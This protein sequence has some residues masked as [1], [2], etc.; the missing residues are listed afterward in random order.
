MR[1]QHIK[2]FK[3]AGITIQVNSAYPFGKDTFSKHIRLFETDRPEKNAIIINHNFYIPDHSVYHELLKN[4]VF[5]TEQWQVY[6]T[7]KNWM[8]KYTPHLPGDPDH[9][10]IGIFNNEHNKADIYTDG[11][12]KNKYQRCEFRALTLFN[13]D[14]ILFSKLLCSRKGLIIHSNGFNIN[15]NGIL[16]TGKSGAGKS[17]LSGMLKQKGFEILCDDRM[18]VQKKSEHFYIFGNWCHGSV[19]DVSTTSMP[20]KAVFFLK[21]APINKISLIEGAALKNK[22]I[23]KSM[24]NSFFTPEEWEMAFNTIEKLTTNV[25]FFMIEFNLTGEICDIL[26]EHL[27]NK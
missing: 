10:A 27:K 15:G 7:R 1:T 12:D 20:L 5:K 25:N 9:T 26:E 14:Q 17:T 13:T 24:V 16:L 4:Q 23:I 21:Q 2:Y 19:P 3:I 6:Q 18:L 11:I 22:Y 8:Y